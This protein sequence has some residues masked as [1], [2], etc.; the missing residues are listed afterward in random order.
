MIKLKVTYV[1][2]IL[3]FSA[4]QACGGKEEIIA[5]DKEAPKTG[6]TESAKKVI[7]FAES[8]LKDIQSIH[9]TVIETANS[10]MYG[11]EE[12]YTGDIV[13]KFGGK[14]GTAG[15]QW[16]E[17]KQ[18][19]K[20]KNKH[21]RGVF[22]SEGL[23]ELHLNKK[24]V[25]KGDKNANSA[26]WITGA[27]SWIYRDADFYT[28]MKGISSDNKSTQNNK[29]THRIWLEAIEDVYG[30][31]CYVIAEINPQIEKFVQRYY[32]GANDGFYYGNTSEATT[33]EGYGINKTLI[34]KLSINDELPQFDV[35]VPEDFTVE[36]YVAP[37]D[38]KNIEV[39]MQAPDW[40]LPN[41][42]G[43]EQ[44]LSKEYTENIVL[45]DFWA[46]WC[47]P[48]KAKMPFVQK[49][50][51]K[52]KSKGFKVISVLSGD[53]GHEKEAAEYIKKHNYTFDLVFGTNALS[54][55]YK[56]RFLPTVMLL[57]NTGK[58]VHFRDTPGVN[59][60][61][62]EKIELENA[63]KKVLKL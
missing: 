26:A 4:L 32:F 6:T 54:D 62:D 22:T 36:M 52:Y 60:N 25:I 7:A 50:Y 35:E 46:T 14:P 13:M 15:D 53:V 27:F 43:G 38:A 10:E 40:T 56:I 1:L 20:G 5:I 16:F 51:D 47:G 37:W 17:S 28:K 19:V 34:K 42:E 45:L 31:R 11:S 18:S 49:M 48:C 8:K 39:G 41:Q 21:I 63:I 24:K 33:S 55:T 3:V 61:V 58:I 29:N 2:F 59:D 44:T 12:I 23:K 57:D 30:T 9:A